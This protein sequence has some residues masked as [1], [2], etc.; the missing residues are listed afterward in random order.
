MTTPKPNQ[1]D[2]A[3]IDGADEQDHDAAEVA[4]GAVLAA[5]IVAWLLPGPSSFLPKNQAWK[6]QIQSLLG[7]PLQAFIQRSA[8]DLA[9]QTALPNASLL[10]A[11]AATEVYPKILH[12]VEGWSDQS[13][14]HL[15]DKDIAQGELSQTVQ[16]TAQNLARSLAVTAKS[17]V[18]DKTAGKLG[19]LWKQW[20]TRHDDRVRDS[21]A[22]L[23]Y[24]SVPMDG[25][26]ITDTG[27]MLRWPGDPE[28][29]I[30]ETAGCR[31]HLVYRIKPHDTSY[32]DV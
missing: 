1:Q 7:P 32:A 2:Q 5:M 14:A 3:E 16:T 22:S 23:D 15:T 6:A 28:A 10:A 20:K 25:M 11:E 30:S 17:E 12:M 24:R 13:L 8:F 18:R 19:A 21:H 29:S 27:A 4:F 26:F 31:C 9:A